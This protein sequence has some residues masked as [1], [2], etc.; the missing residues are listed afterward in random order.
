VSGKTRVGILIG[1]RGS[2]MEALVQAAAHEDF[3]AVIA[4]VL[5]NNPAAP[6]LDLARDAGVEALAIDH[7]P[8]GRDRAAH[9]RAMDDA[10]RA[11]GV[12]VVCL[13][14]YLR[15]LT[16]FLVRRWQG[17]M[18]NIHPSLLPD[19]PGLQTHARAL[20]AGA[21]RHGCTV[22]LVTDG[23]D[24]GPILAQ[25]DVPVL[26]GDD[27][28]TLAARVLAEEHRLYPQALKTL[29]SRLDLPEG[30]DAP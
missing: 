14:G 15:L 26:P 3:P 9:E 8:F 2:N 7:R 10:L 16:P 6:G 13:A 17:R 23:M 28:A 12:Q 4:V 27:E 18:L 20:Q 24:E 25:A 30:P 5:S 22:H 29:V 19:F 1:G 11:R 21:T